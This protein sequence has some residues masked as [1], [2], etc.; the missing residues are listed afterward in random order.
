M[1]CLQIADGYERKKGSKDDSVIFYLNN[2][3]KI[4]LPSTNIRESEDLKEFD[5]ERSL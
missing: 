1:I 4:E 3:K 2:F 5:L